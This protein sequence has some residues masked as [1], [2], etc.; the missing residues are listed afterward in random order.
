MNFEK[1][2]QDPVIESK[3]KPP[4][5]KMRIFI[6]RHGEPEEYAVKDAA[7]SGRGRD[8]VQEFAK[9]FLSDLK[10]KQETGAA[11]KILYSGI[12]RTKESGEI[13]ER[14][15]EKGIGEDELKNITL[16]NSHERKTLQT[17]GTLKP[18]MDAGVPKNEAYQRWIGASEEELQ[19]VGAKTPEEVDKAMSELIR[20]MDEMSTRL[21]PGPEVDYVW[22]THETTHGAILKRLDPEGKA[23]I[24]FVEP[25]EID[26]GQED[27]GIKYKFRDQEFVEMPSEK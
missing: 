27:G 22:V 10:G 3:E 23:N 11:V 7:L 12:S 2:F 19:L 8:Q 20:G 5:R 18:L 13:L 1:S 24:G 26:I 16:L 9:N 15:L 25:L 14:E 6:V 21:G 17:T 4:R